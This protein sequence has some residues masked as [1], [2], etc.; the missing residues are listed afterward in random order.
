MPEQF[1]KDEAEKLATPFLEYIERSVK[2]IETA[3]TDI[4]RVAAREA[5]C[6][7]REQALDVRSN[8]LAE[9]EAG[10]KAREE[11]VAS[12]E[13]NSPVFQFHKLAADRLA[14]ISVLK[15]NQQQLIA[16]KEAAEAEAASARRYARDLGM[17]PV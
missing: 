14:Q 5:G 13:R 10:L 8:Q 9:I 15:D 4:E 3:E 12:L 17:V 6:I 1:S 11:K 16:Q 7:E 2:R